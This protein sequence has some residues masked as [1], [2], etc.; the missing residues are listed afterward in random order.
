MAAV[1]SPTTA[2]S[3]LDYR[4]LRETIVSVLARGHLNLKFDRCFKVQEFGKRLVAK[5]ETDED[6][7]VTALSE[8]ITALL[9]IL[10]GILKEASSLTG[11]ALQRERA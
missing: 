8:C 3:E 7:T 6:N 4:Y 2:A 1:P 11:C 5:I 9:K 10:D